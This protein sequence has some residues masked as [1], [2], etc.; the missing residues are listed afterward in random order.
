MCC[1]GGG[2]FEGVNG[3]PVRAAQPGGATCE[4]EVW[5]VAIE[6]DVAGGE[7]F[8]D[9]DDYG[10]LHACSDGPECGLMDIK[11]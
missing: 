11:V 7:P 3:P 1:G 8:E 5:E 9:G 6:D 4:M 10:D 2:P